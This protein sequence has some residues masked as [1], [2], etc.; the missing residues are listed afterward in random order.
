MDT[1]SLLVVAAVVTQATNDKEQ[2]VPMLEQIAALPASVG[3]VD[4][5]LA[6]TGFFSGKYVAAC[7]AAA[8]E[9]LSAVA[10][11]EHHAGWRERFTEP[12]PI[13]ADATPVARMAHRL[14]TKAGRTAYALRKQTVEPVFGIIKS[15]LGFRQF[16]L[17]GPD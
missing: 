12:E 13:P 1:G 14:K 10:R 8:V 17:R 7:E 9:P 16:L 6:D 3:T 4:R 11:D 15:V 5:L 2:V